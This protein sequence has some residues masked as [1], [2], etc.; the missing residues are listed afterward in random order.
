MS[1]RWEHSPEP[2]PG[3]VTQLTNHSAVVS[4]ETM[5]LADMRCLSSDAQAMELSSSQSHLILKGSHCRNYRPDLVSRA[6]SGGCEGRM[7]SGF[8]SVVFSGLSVMCTLP[9]V[10]C[11][12]LY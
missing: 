2:G 5:V 8:L 3:G 9:T 11:I 6:E 4:L 10:D 7:L 1:D 12:L